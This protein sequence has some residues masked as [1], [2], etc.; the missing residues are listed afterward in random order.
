MNEKPKYTMVYNETF[1]TRERDGVIEHR[2]AGFDYWH[3]VSR[4]HEGCGRIERGV[5]YDVRMCADCVSTG[6]ISLCHTRRRQLG[7]TRGSVAHGTCPMVDYIGNPIRL[8][9]GVTEHMH[10]GFDYWHP[11][12]RWHTDGLDMADTMLTIDESID[13]L[14]S[15]KSMLVY[16]GKNSDHVYQARCE[17][18]VSNIDD[19]VGM[20]L[21]ISRHTDEDMEERRNERSIDHKC[22]GRVGKR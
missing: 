17:Q 2:H 19:I 18:L 22:Y 20:L 15:A 8:V 7:L 13:D 6:D 1:P 14:V 10:P 3:P 11:A 5:E 12:S 4:T 9:N 16:V 21:K